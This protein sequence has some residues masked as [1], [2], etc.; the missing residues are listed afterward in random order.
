MWFLWYIS[1]YGFLGDA[2]TLF[3]AHGQAIGNSILYLGIGAIGYPVGAIV[4]SVLA[5]RVER[6]LLIFGA[7]LVWLAGMVVIGT[8]AGEAFG[9]AGIGVTGVLAGLVALL[10]PRSSGRRLESVPR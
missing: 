10:G 7:S 5:D 9:F 8:L 3:A 1:N 2:A 4:M 6:K